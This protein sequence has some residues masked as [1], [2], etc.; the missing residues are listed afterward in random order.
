MLSFT[1]V[2]ISFPGV[3]GGAAPA[4]A[5]AAPAPAGPP[6]PLEQ[7]RLRPELAAAFAVA[8]GQGEPATVTWPTDRAPQWTVAVRR[9]GGRAEYKVDDMS[10]EARL[11]PVRPET[12]ARTMRRWHDGDGMGLVWQIVIFLGG[13]APALLAVT[14]VIMW[15]R[16]RKWRERVGKRRAAAA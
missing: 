4:A 6:L 3:F 1:G 16:T 13:I 12:L 14:G 7:P 8:A 10:G 9:E 2:W 15:L 11:Q 5:A